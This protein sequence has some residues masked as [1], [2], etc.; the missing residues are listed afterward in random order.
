MD[1]GGRNT[2]NAKESQ[3]TFAKDLRENIKI[4]NLLVAMIQMSKSA[5]KFV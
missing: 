5:R 2:K 4:A 3:K 1:A